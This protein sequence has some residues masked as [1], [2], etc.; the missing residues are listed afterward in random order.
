MLL[1]LRI[2]DVPKDKNTHTKILTDPKAVQVNGQAFCF[3]YEMTIKRGK[4]TYHRKEVGSSVGTKGRRIDDLKN[5]WIGHVEDI[6]EGEPRPTIKLKFYTCLTDLCNGWWVSTTTTTTTTPQP[7][8]GVVI[9]QPDDDDDDADSELGA[10][11]KTKPDDEDADSELK[12]ETKAKPDLMAPKKR[13]TLKQEKI[14]L[15]QFLM[16]QI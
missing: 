8:S 11:T 6:L 14:H 5:E 16:G 15:A 7:E 9:V 4:N 10:E 1:M 2:S 3:G 12:A 13:K